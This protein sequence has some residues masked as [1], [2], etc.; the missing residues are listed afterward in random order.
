LYGTL[1]PKVDRTIAVKMQK[2]LMSFVLTGDPNTLWAEDKPSWPLYGNGTQEIV[3]NNDQEFY[4]RAD[5]LVNERSAFWN[6]GL[7]Y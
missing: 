1:T 4:L 7:W 2:Y 6:Q 5:D 3:F